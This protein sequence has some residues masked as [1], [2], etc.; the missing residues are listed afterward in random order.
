MR[1][2]ALFAL[3]I[4]TPSLL[5]AAPSIN[6]SPTDVRLPAALV[7]AMEDYDR[8]QVSG[9]RVELTRLLADDYVLVNGG[10]EIENKAQ[11]IADFTDPAF[12]LSPYVV[13]HPNRIAWADGAVLAGEVE[14]TGTNAGKPFVAH[15][16]YADIWRLRAGRWQV[17]FTQV[18]RFPKKEGS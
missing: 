5:A 14:L 1:I 6:T 8:A 16:R 11:L 17:V 9:N 4:G 13:Q 3:A 7:Q 15:T 12:K 10:A 2:L 18:T